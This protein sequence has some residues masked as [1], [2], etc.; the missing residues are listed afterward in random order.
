VA[1]GL[2]FARGLAV[3]PDGDLCVA[4]PEGWNRGSGRLV[5]VQT[6]VQRRR[7]WRKHGQLAAAVIDP[8]NQEERL[9]EVF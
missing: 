9:C 4:E 6:A 1:R 7:E 5:R 8:L 3:L 2:R